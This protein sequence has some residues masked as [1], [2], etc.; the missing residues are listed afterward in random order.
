MKQIPEYAND[1]VYLVNLLCKTQF[2]TLWEA[3]TGTHPS[4]IHGIIN[5][6]DRYELRYLI[7][8]IEELL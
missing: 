5:K 4:N 2:K 3:K 8:K 7:T 1:K 6:L